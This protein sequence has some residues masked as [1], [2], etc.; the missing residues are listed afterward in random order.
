VVGYPSDYTLFTG[1]SAQL[2]AP[3]N[4]PSAI[5]ISPEYPFNEFAQI[6]WV[7]NSV[8]NST[9]GALQGDSKTKILSILDGTSNTIL[10]VEAAGRPN[11][12]L[13][14]RATGLMLSGNYGGFGG[15][16]DPTSAGSLLWGSDGAGNG[17]GG[18]VVMNAS[19]DYDIY[20]FHGV[21]ANCGFCDGSVHF[22]NTTI[23][24]H[25]IGCLL[26][27]RGGEVDTNFGQ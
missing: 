14:N 5:A 6:P 20:A 8:P 21:G 24:N 4:V 17:P 27:G 1:E 26:T 22:L 25:T 23:P 2:P 10:M 7:V 12:Y 15:W 16:A 19:N 18:Q 3:N 9:I 11:L 13:N